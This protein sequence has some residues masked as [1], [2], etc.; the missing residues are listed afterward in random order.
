MRAGEARREAV[1]VVVQFTRD[2]F[3]RALCPFCGTPH[4]YILNADDLPHEVRARCG[5]GPLYLVAAGE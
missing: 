5:R 2:G 3:P 4:R 1:A